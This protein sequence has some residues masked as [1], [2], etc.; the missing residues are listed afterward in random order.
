MSLS[1]LSDDVKTI[2]Q[3]AADHLPGNLSRVF[4]AKVVKALGP[5]GQR[6]AERELDW[7]RKTIRKGQRELDRGEPVED[8]FSARGRK[9]AEEHLS[10]LLD[11]IRDLVEPTSQADPTFRTTHL[12]TPL[13]AKEVRRRLIEDK[14]YTDEELPDVRT[15]TTKL[16]QLDYRPQKVAKSKPIKKIAETDAIFEQ[17]HKVNQAADETQGV[18]RVSMDAKAKIKIGPFSRGGTSRQG[19]AGSDHDFD[20]EE[21]LTPVGVFLP[22]HDDIYLYFTRGPVTADFIVDVLEKVWP[23]LKT[24]FKL[25]TLVVDLDNGPENNSHRTQFIK[26]LVEFAGKYGINLRLAYYPP[27]HSKYNPIERVWGVLENHWNGELLDTVEKALGLARTMTWRGKPPVI[28]EL[29]NKVYEKGIKLSKEAM[30]VY[31]ALIDRL[32]GLEKWFVDI[33]PCYALVQG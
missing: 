1:D 18:V 30:E 27:Y 10:N 21:I 25:H 6:Q 33:H 9:K 5:G 20:P 2:L 7:N 19:N 8:N 28:V 12:Y 4:K 16:N 23:Q 24:R 31:E 14:G 17:V 32:S 22:A 26:R 29:V 3:Y 13:T 15:I 11:D